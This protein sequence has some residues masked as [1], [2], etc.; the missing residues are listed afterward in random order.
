MIPIIID[1]RSNVGK[2]S[3]VNHMLN[4][5]RS[6]K[7]ENTIGINFGLK[8]Y[9]LFNQNVSALF[10]DLAG[11][12]KYDFLRV[13]FY[14]RAACL[15]LVCDVTLRKTSKRFDYFI[16][17]ADEMGLN[18]DKI[19]LCGSKSDLDKR[20]RLTTEKLTQLANTYGLSCSIPTSIVSNTNVDILFEYALTLGLYS[21][22]RI[23][24][25]QFSFYKKNLQE[26]F[27]YNFKSF[28]Q[29]KRKC[30]VCKRTIYFDE[31]IES[32][33]F[34]SN[35]RLKKLWTSDYLEFYCC[36]CYKEKS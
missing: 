31:F 4:P 21:L 2:T 22:G 3:L 32:N 17:L 16:E 25:S 7:P 18:R 34:L 28:P 13:S 35:K 20:T 9:F 12:P 23:K 26:I 14:K 10:W 33:S 36:S 5:T 15:I 6:K 11:K 1:G 24:E 30:W 29:E 8:N 27:K 19:I